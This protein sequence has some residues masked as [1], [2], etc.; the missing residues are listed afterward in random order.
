MGWLATRE[1]TSRNHAN[2]STPARFQEATKLRSTALVFPPWPLPKNVQL[3]RPLDG[4][5]Q[6]IV[7][8][9]GAAAIAPARA[10]AAD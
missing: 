3:F 4:A 6:D 8:R 9:K 2:G 1:S 5:I 7:G 10:G